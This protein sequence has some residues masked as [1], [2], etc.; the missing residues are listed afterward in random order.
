VNHNVV[1]KDTEDETTKEG[2]QKEKS[3]L[4]E[5]ATALAKPPKVSLTE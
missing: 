5:A 4:E 3:L 1:V 2:S